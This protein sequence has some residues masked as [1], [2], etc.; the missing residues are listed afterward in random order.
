MG[1]M[2]R[3]GG[4]IV[5]PPP[6]ATHGQTLLPI[7]FQFARG[8]CP[9]AWVKLSARLVA[10]WLAGPL[11]R[12]AGPRGWPAGCL[13]GSGDG[14]RVGWRAPWAWW[15]SLLVSTLMGGADTPMGVFFASHRQRANG[16]APAGAPPC[17]PASLP[18]AGRGAAPVVL[19]NTI[20]PISVV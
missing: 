1:R 4:E 20:S 15:R 7:Y 18:G 17:P 2:G 16:R 14:R 6:R 19:H 3:S 13:A 9:W 5:Q 8:V 10:S 11:C 12:L